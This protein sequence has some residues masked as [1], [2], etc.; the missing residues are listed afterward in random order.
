LFEIR[1]VNPERCSFSNGQRHIVSIKVSI[2]ISTN[3]LQEKI[4]SE[5]YQITRT[6]PI[7]KTYS[8]FDMKLGYLLKKHFFS[9]FSI[10]FAKL[11]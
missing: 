1:E 10:L 2:K 4:E 3:K 8:K 9:Y 6:Y 7:C 11:L 5:C